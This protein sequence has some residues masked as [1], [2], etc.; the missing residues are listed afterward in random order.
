MGPVLQSLLQIYEGLN[1]WGGV[2]EQIQAYNSAKTILVDRVDGLH[3]DFGLIHR[4][5]AVFYEEK[6]DYKA[7][8][9]LG[10][11]TLLIATNCT[12]GSIWTPFMEPVF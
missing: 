4:C 10:E 9:T 5:T 1:C 3:L 2:T 7:G 12:G 11:S 6:G 8:L